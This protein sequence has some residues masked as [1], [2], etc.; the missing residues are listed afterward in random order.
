MSDQ[1]KIVR[2]ETCDERNK[3]T[4]RQKYNEDKTRQNPKAKAKRQDLQK[5]GRLEIRLDKLG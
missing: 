1:K 4:Q 5:L 3:V 2:V